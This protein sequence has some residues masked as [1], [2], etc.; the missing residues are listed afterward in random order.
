MKQRRQRAPVAS[1]V[2]RE[3]KRQ[4]DEMWRRFDCTGVPAPSWMFPAVVDLYEHI[5]A[6][7]L[8][9]RLPRLPRSVSYAGKRYLVETTSFGR[10]RVLEPGTRR[11]IVASGIGALW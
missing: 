8:A 3:I 9:S 2:H 4:T 1:P 7:L 5:L 11:L 10:L 6:A